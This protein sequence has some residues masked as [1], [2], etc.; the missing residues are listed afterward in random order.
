MKAELLEVTDG[1]FVNMPRFLLLRLRSAALRPSLDDGTGAGVLRYH[2]GWL[3][4]VGSRLVFLRMAI[5]VAIFSLFAI[6][7]LVADKLPGIP[8]RN[9]AVSLV[10]DFCPADS[11]GW[12]WRSRDM[13]RLRWHFSWAG[14]VDWP[15]AW[16]D[17]MSVAIW[18]GALKLPDFPVALTED[19]IAI[20]TGLFIVSRF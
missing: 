5:C 16:A 20:G 14:L 11:A 19:L 6:G 15:A 10:S 2:L 18:A 13:L 4:L 3:N 17:I 12:C 1:R 8:G 9:T 7:E